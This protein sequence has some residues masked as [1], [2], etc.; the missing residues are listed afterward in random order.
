MTTNPLKRLID[1]TRTK[2]KSPLEKT[3]LDIFQTEEAPKYR[4]NTACYRCQHALLAILFIKG[5]QAKNR[6]CWYPAVMACSRFAVFPSWPAESGG[7]GLNTPI[8]DPS[9]PFYCIGALE[10]EEA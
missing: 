3:A 8:P 2:L 9:Q 4:D 7:I 5:D 6:P 1:D 10:K